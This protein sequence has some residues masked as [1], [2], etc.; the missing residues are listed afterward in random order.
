M[1][2]DE[3]SGVC[4]EEGCKRID[5]GCFTGEF[6]LDVGE[7]EVDDEEVCEVELADEEGLS[8]FRWEIRTGVGNREAVG[9]S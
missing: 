7:D 2:R 1:G 6:P 5:G 4:V 8:R 9:G 3:K